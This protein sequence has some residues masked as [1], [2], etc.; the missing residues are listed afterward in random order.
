MHK[1]R[2][3]GGWGYRCEGDVGVGLYDNDESAMLEALRKLSELVPVE[4]EAHD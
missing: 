4:G 1:V 3:G 2:V